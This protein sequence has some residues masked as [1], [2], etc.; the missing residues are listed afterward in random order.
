MCLLSSLNEG[1]MLCADLICI[2]VPTE[3]SRQH[4]VA[5]I[6]ISCGTV[7]NGQISTTINNALDKIVRGLAPVAP[8]L[9]TLDQQINSCIAGVSGQ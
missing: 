9:K 6:S 7:Y 4:N 2:L 3:Q 1:G 5:Q 8:T